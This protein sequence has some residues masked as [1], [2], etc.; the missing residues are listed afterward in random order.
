MER[1]AKKKGVRR[2]M[3]LGDN[4]ELRRLAAQ[5]GAG[6]SKPPPGRPSGSGGQRP[7]SGGG[8]PPQQPSLPSKFILNSFYGS[9]GKLRQEIFYDLPRELAQLLATQKLPKTRKPVS[10]GQLRSLY[11]GMARF[12]KPLKEG[13]IDL[14]TA[15]ESFGHFYVQRVVYQGKRGYLPSCLVELIDVHRPLAMSA[16]DEMYG[17][18]LLLKHVLCYYEEPKEGRRE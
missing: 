14:A 1:E 11:T 13:K 8:K 17:L 10:M 2:T 12:A 6:Q 18:F 3:K 4:P 9:D 16:A 15:C 7:S 5:V